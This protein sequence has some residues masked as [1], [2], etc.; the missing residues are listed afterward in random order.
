MRKL[1]FLCALI[2]L[3]N[4]AQAQVDST[5]KETDAFVQKVIET[6]TLKQINEYLY[7][8]MTAKQYAEFTNHIQAYLRERYNQWKAKK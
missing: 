1:A 4:T 8:H 7:E 5:Q 2:A 3:I 6:T